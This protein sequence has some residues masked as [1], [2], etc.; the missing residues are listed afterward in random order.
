MAPVAMDPAVTKPMAA[1][2]AAAGPAKPAAVVALGGMAALAAPAERRQEPLAT[3][4]RVRRAAAEAA[5]AP[6]GTSETRPG[7][8]TRRRASPGG[9]AEMAGR[10]LMGAVAAAAAAA[11]ALSGMC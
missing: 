11:L 9:A 4:A 6:M 2:A 3:P 8:K 1:V 7:W 5:A 10:A